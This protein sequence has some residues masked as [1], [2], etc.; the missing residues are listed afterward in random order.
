MRSSIAAAAVL[1]AVIGTLVLAMF[2]SAATA[3]EQY[4]ALVP[5]PSVLDYTRGDG[6]GIVLGLGVEYGNAYDGSDEMEF[7]LEPAA[8]IQWRTD[9]HLFFWEGPFLGWRS[10]MADVWL[11]QLAAQYEAGR[12]SD[13]SDDGRLDGLEEPDDEVVAQF[14]VRRALDSEWRNWIGIR[15]K[16]GD[17]DRGVI[18]TIGAG[19]RFGD[20]LDGTGTEAFLY[21]TF[22]NSDHLHRD[23][24]V[25]AEESVTSGLEETDLD[26]GHRSIGIIV[27]D[28]RYVSQH[29]QIFSE[30][31]FEYYSDEVK[32]SPIARVDYEV[33][34]RVGAV[35]HF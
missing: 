34:F 18:L 14:G 25:T 23:F 21:G 12:E 24:G 32:D 19:H 35:Y 17:S 10:R 6:W 31:G 30:A 8:V 3:A 5:S 9:N 16:V 4:E 7:E 1:L 33:E 29:V 28:R 13:E 22:A 15:S 27:I 20:N 11:V 2:S 26:G